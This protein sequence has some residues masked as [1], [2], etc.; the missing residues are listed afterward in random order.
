MMGSTSPPSPLVVASVASIVIVA[1]LASLAEAEEANVLVGDPINGRKLY[2]STCASCHGDGGMGGPSGLALT[3]ANRLNLLRDEQLYA[4]IRTGEGTKDPSKHAFKD[5]L[6]FLDI[7]DI[8]AHTRTLHMNLDAFF[9]DSS[10]YISKIYQIDENG[11]KRIEAATGKRPQQTRAAVFTFFRFEGEEGHLTYVPQDPILLDQ[12]EKRNKVGYLV[13]LPFDVPGF[14][15]QEIGIGM[16][17]RGVITKLAVDER[18]PG[19]DAINATLVRLTGQGRLGLRDRFRV[20]GPAKVRAM[21]T[22][23]YPV[24]QRAMETVTQYVVEERER[25]W[26]DSA[27]R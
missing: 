7:W 9:P 14:T 12:L 8:V 4:I 13:F 22:K 15:G 23:V 27:V 5:Q 20:K 11:L 10:R 25:T 6:E 19:A 17:S 3:S 2:Q 16:D 18:L 21:A 1:G 24:Y 26:A